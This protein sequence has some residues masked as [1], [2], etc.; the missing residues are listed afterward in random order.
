MSDGSVKIPESAWHRFGESLHQF[1]T[2]AV[3]KKAWLLAA[4]LIG[5]LLVINGLN[6]L[7]SY[8]GRDFFSSIERRDSRSFF[9]HTVF[10][11]GVFVLLTGAS[12]FYRFC[13]ERLA[14]LWREWLTR[15]FVG[16]YLGQRV[17]YHLNDTGAIKNVDQRIAD[18]IKAFTTVTLSFVLMLLNANFTILAFSGVLWSISWLLFVVAVAYA[19]VGSLLTYYLGKPLIGLNYRQLDREADFRRDLLHVVEHA[20]EIALLHR[21]GRV[22][23]R[24]RQRINELVANMRRMIAVNRNLA[25]FTN[26]Y[27]YLIQIIPALIVAPLFIAGKV[28]FGVIAQA[29]M[30]F[31]HLLGAFSLLITQFQSF[32]NYA[33]VVVRLGS[34]GD[35]IGGAAKR[36]E[37]MVEVCEQCGHIRFENLTLE[38]PKNGGI[39][40][41]DFNL[42]VPTGKSTLITGSG[43]AAQIALFRATAGIWPAGKGRITRPNL[44]LAFFVPERPYLLAGTLRETV[45]RSGAETHTSDEEMARLLHE[46]NLGDFL[47]RAGGYDTRQQW[48]A[49]ASLAEQQLLVAARLLISRPEFAVLDRIGTALTPAQVH[50]V[51]TKLRER[52]IT[53]LVIGTDGGQLR[54]FDQV[55]DLSDDGSWHVAQ[56]IDGQICGG[57]TGI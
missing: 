42:T 46:L 28:E 27:N 32:S 4:G 54:Y 44:D 56:V 39:L 11:L 14:L 49:V 9:L 6:V 2:S 10:Y 20:D 45:L 5:L 48:E 25:F 55:V 34:L 16:Q 26:G 17:Y 15:S 47:N 8:V 52:N 53:S 21:E 38:S 36:E 18:D 29:T 30:A 7:N 33:A 50:L 43:V 19:L 24:L 13:E 31:A 51:L 3:R 22:E 35:A 12:A 1:F 41:R 57:E 37:G 23:S 40:L